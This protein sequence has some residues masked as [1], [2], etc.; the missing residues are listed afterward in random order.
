VNRLVEDRLRLLAEKRRELAH[1]GDD[2][3]PPDAV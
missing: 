2:D 1:P 3:D